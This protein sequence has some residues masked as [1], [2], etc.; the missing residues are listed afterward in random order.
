MN[1]LLPR[2]HGLWCWVAA[3]LLAAI[4]VAGSPGALAGALALVCGFGAANAARARAWRHAAVAGLLG[5]GLAVLAGALLP[6]PRLWTTAVVIVALGAGAAVVTVGRRGG[7]A[8]R[9]RSAWEVAAVLGPVAIGAALALAAD[10][11]P[12][13]V[14]VVAV[15]LA[16]FELVGLWWV[17]RVLAP[18]LPGRHP[19][20]GGNTLPAVAVGVSVV[21]GFVC[22]APVAG[23]LPLLYAAR[24]I[25]TSPPRSGKDA[26]R[27]GLSEAAWTAAVTLLLVGVTR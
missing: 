8:V 1:P 10:A 15:G 13:R 19:F 23:G 27:L 11:P 2:E 5:T 16:A 25:T 17:R 9:G 4:L 7:H 24:S 21:V 22:G 3:P 20:P 26:R 6:N 18:V 12:D 14:A